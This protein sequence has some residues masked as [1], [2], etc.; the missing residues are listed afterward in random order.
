MNVIL[1][2]EVLDLLGIDYITKNITERIFKIEVVTTTYE[3]NT[4]AT[5]AIYYDEKTK[6]IIPN[7]EQ[8]RQIKEQIKE[9]K[10][11]LKEL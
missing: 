10:K 3:D 7:Y 4:V 11:Q 8:K 6:Q 5:K 2:K 1:I 9:L